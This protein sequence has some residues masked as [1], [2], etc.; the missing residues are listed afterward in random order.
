TLWSD[1]SNWTNC[2]GVAPSNDHW[3]HIPSAQASQPSVASNLSIMG[4]LPGA[5]DGVITIE[6]GNTLTVLS[7]AMRSSVKFQGDSVD[8]STC[9]VSLVESTWVIGGSSLNLGRGITL[10]MA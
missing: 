4:F 7:N 6:A 8:C 5:D 2:G 10:Q 1:P 3:V 9:Y